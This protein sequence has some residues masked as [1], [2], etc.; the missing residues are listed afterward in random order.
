MVAEDTVEQEEGCPGLELVLRKS[1]LAN[2]YDISI[3]RLCVT[4][5]RPKAKESCPSSEGT[6]LRPDG[7]VLGKRYAEPQP[8][9]T[10][11]P[12]PHPT[13]THTQPRP[14]PNPDPHPTQAHT[15]P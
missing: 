1:R 7:K 14:T 4:D 13:Q 15:Q 5:E 9:P 10:P 8:T 2:L 12:H 3:G 11:N 6:V